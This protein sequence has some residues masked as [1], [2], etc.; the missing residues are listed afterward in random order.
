M[1]ASR[2]RLASHQSPLLLAALKQFVRESRLNL[3]PSKV[4][5]STLRN[6][7]AGLKNQATHDLWIYG[8]A[9]D[10]YCLARA[11]RDADGAAVYTAYQLWIDPAKR[12]GVMVRRIVRGLRSYA[13]ARGYARMYVMSSRLDC[14]KAYARG[15]GREFTARAVVFGTDLKGES[16]CFL[17][18]RKISR[19]S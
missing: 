2:N 7:D 18:P 12:D 6:I 13:R 5:L 16:Q 3:D 15:L 14:V 9:V 17:K 8:D 4:L 10:A 19:P 1:K 11:E